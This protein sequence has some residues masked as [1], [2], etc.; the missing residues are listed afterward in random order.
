MEDNI[1]YLYSVF[2]NMVNAG[3]YSSVK[4]IERAVHNGVIVATLN[5]FYISDINKAALNPYSSEDLT[6]TLYDVDI[7][8]SGIQYTYDLKNKSIIRYELYGDLLLGNNKERSIIELIE[9]EEKRTGRKI[10][11]I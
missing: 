8:C 2:R 7:Y 6:N 9:W 11:I 1:C 5:I 10:E 4:S 3:I